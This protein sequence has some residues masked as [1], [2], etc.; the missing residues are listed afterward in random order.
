MP[1]LTIK[2]IESVFTEN[3]KAEMIRKVTDAMVSVEGEQM[4]GVTW[5][6]FEEVKSGDWAIGGNRAS[7]SPSKERR[8]LKF[9][10]ELPKSREAP[11]RCDAETRSASSDASRG[12][13]LDPRLSPSLLDGSSLANVAP[14]LGGKIM[15]K[16][17]LAS[18]AA[19]L[20]AI[21]F[22]ADAGLQ[23]AYPVAPQGLQQPD[24]AKTFQAKGTR[25][26]M[27][28]T[29]AQINNN[30]GPPDWFPDEHPAMP[31]IV[32]NGR[33]PHVR[34][35]MLCHLPHGNGHPESA[36]VSGLTA[37]YIVEQMHEFRDGNRTNNRA[38]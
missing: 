3:Q 27:M 15:K 23:W 37:N 9:Q 22:G 25:T 8:I 5:V 14:P 16:L 33:A 6:L 29:M 36:S 19:L 34:A 12:T 24:P 32:K 13:I 35:C 7:L 28:L 4:R 38:P 26:G 10:S 2:A 18:V 20:P 31:S 11:C 30:F 17:L 1:L 21:A